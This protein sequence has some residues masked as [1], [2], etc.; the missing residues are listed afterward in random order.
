MPTKASWLI[1]MHGWKLRPL[2]KSEDMEIQF[3]EKPMESLSKEVEE[4]QPSLVSFISEVPGPLNAAMTSFIEG[5]PSWDQYR[6]VQAA[7][8]GFLLQNGIE[9]REITR[10]YLDNMFSK[11]SSLQG[12]WTWKMRYLRLCIKKWKTSLQSIQTGINTLW[13]VPH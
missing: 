7:L 10:L 5:H 9:S 12:L 6:L 3:L 2:K 4:S 13:W 11:K 1:R 8:A